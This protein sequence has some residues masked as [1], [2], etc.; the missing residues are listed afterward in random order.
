MNL[1]A[2]S[3]KEKPESQEQPRLSLLADLQ[4]QGPDFWLCDTTEI[5][6]TS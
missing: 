2:S 3:L 5:T 1:K 6:S 4:L